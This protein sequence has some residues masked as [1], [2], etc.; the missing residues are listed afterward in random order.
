MSENDREMLPLR[1]RTLLGEA[2][3]M[4]QST[5]QDALCS[6]PSLPLVIPKCHFDLVPE[7]GTNHMR[8]SQFRNRK[9][10]ANIGINSLRLHLSVLF[11]PLLFFMWKE[12]PRELKYVKINFGYC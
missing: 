9:D 8:C 6:L 2:T 10:L 11:F 12:M 1:L 3:E 7:L 4:L 5:G